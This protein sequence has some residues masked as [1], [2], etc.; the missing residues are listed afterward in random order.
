[1]DNA[2]NLYAGNYTATVTDGVGCTA[3]IG[4]GVT[5]AGAPSVSVVTVTDVSCFGESD[6][7]AL[8]AAAGGTQP[9]TY[10]WD[11][12]L[13][14]TVA[15]PNGLPAGTWA[16]V[17]EDDNDCIATTNIIITE[18]SVLAAGITSSSDVTCFGG[19]DGTATV[20]GNGGTVPYTFSWNNTQT[21]ATAV[22][23]SPV[24][25]VV[26]VTD[27]NNCSVNVS[28]TIGEPLQM[29]ASTT[30]TDAFCN[31]PS[32]Q[33]CASATNGTAP[34]SYDWN[35]GQSNACAGA[36]IPGG[37]TVTITDINTCSVTISAVVG[38]IAPGI[39]SIA[40]LTN[41][42]CFGG[43]DGQACVSYSGNATPFTYLWDANASFQTTQCATGLAQGNYQ[44]SL[45][46]DNGCVVTTNATI[47]QPTVI[48]VTTSVTDA[49]CNAS[50]NGQISILAQGGTDPHTYSWSDPL[51]QNTATA[52]G[53]CA[54]N[55]TV[56]VTDLMG[57]ILSLTETINE[58]SA[59][60]LDSTVISAN[61]GQIDGA[62]C[63]IA[64]GG[65]GNYS[66]HWQNGQTSSC[67]SGLSSSAY[68]VTVTDE[69]LC[70]NALTA[71]VTDLLGPVATIISVTDVM[72]FGES[73]GAVTVSASG[74]TGNFTYTWTDLS[75][76]IVGASPLL[77]NLPSG[78]YNV[79]VRDQNTN[80]TTN[81]SVII[82]EP[83]PIQINPS[84]TNPSCFAA[85][86]GSAS[87]VVSG[88]TTP[89]SYLWA[90][91]PNASTYSGLSSGLYNL[92][93]VDAN[94]CIQSLS[95]TLTNPAEITASVNVTNVSCFGQANGIASVLPANGAGNYSYQWDDSNN[96][97]SQTA[98]NLTAG[99]YEVTV[100][101]GSGCAAIA[102]T[103]ITE[104]SALVAQINGFGDVTCF[105]GND[106]FAQVQL[107][108]GTAPFTYFWSTGVSTSAI[109]TGLSAN[110]WTCNITDVNG[111]TASVSQVISQPSQLSAAIINS[112]NVT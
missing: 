83:T 68:N 15:S 26:A 99:I 107:F 94:S 27:D 11:D 20:G 9:Y 21:T 75:N 24:N 55:Y 78:N 31:T 57:C 103:I 79:L 74:G 72:C 49:L 64:S 69:N 40:G 18:P 45:T 46:D 35:N 86:D 48:S 39:A 71:N 101:D 106:G 13:A 56:T 89:Y 7:Y 34:I 109:A 5:D 85:T 51:Q 3:T 37:Y 29:V 32:G 93:I 28:V 60:Q 41:V 44:V 70:A 14:Q 98:F 38:N 62:A 61:C 22:G 16:V 65:M 104:P 52:T 66:Y 23:L 53:L 100:T 110:T 112:N 77:N 97:I 43:Y 6:G 63:V 111:C 73:T 105:G 95:Y 84:F 19:T 1:T 82:T 54:G 36:L 92:D 76:N 59:I 96:Q 2:T 90:G 102:S 10:L 67:I 108:G 4:Q 58:P 17:V 91:I 81:A 87:V 30:V 12:P 33:I 42:S 88:G 80:C 50:C 8:V 25:Y 47:N